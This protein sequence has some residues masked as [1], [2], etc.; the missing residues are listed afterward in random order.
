M[1]PRH[2]RGDSRFLLGK[3]P[4][5]AE[6]R[7]EL[8]ASVL[9]AA[10]LGHSSGGTC[11]I[12]ERTASVEGFAKGAPGIGPWKEDRN[13]ALERAVGY[14]PTTAHLVDERSH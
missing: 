7:V 14:A 10:E 6:E 2:S 9:A 5:Y 13:L 3:A 1:P 8:A 12:M 4:A 11:D